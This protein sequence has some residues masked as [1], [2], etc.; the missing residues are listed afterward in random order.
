MSPTPKKRAPATKTRTAS[1]PAPARRKAAS[2]TET[3]QKKATPVY[4]TREERW[5]MVAE[6]AYHKAEKRGFMPGRE[7][8][9]WLDAEREIDVLFGGKK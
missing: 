9:D 4:M 8:E 3:A 5:R 6:A 7:V 2:P 1:K